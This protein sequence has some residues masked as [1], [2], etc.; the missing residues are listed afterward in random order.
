MSAVKRKQ[1]ALVPEVNSSLGDD[2]PLSSLASKRT[3]KTYE[4]KCSY[5]EIDMSGYVEPEDKL[6][7]LAFLGLLLR[8]LGPIL[9]LRP[10]SF[11]HYPNRH[12]DPPNPP[13]VSLL[14]DFTN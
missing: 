11:K 12:P 6:S 7:K 1:P 4:V 8:Q 10:H 5:Q 9:T 2:A 3:R 14:Y 13:V